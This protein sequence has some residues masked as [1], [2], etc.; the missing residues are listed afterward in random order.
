MAR[1]VRQ[2]QAGPAVTLSVGELCDAAVSRLRRV[3][4]EGVRLSIDVQPDLWVRHTRGAL[5]QVLDNLLNNALDAVRGEAS[6]EIELSV[7]AV[8]PFGADAVEVRVRDNGPGV[9]AHLVDT[10][11][12]PFVSSKGARGTGLGLAT[13]AELVRRADGQ[14]IHRRPL[15]GRGAE[16]L[17]LLPAVASERRE[18]PPERPVESKKTGRLGGIRVL[19][20]DDEP[21]LAGM[22]KRM[23]AREGAEVLTASDSSEALQAL[24]EPVDVVLLDR[25]LGR[26]RGADLVPRLRAEAGRAALLYF[27]GGLVPEEERAEVDGVVP[28]PVRRGELVAVLREAAGVAP[29]AGER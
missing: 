9:P 18:A 20:V 23:L 14:I 27:T 22:V 19:V 7:R 16:F 24:Q 21:A 10:L 12:E 13:A 2:E 6:P 17:L 3:A 8:Q 28:K 11:F 29:S 4:A 25:G 5:D 1:M 15:S 26:E